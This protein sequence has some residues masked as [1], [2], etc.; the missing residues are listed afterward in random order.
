[1]GRH[2]GRF[3]GLKEV[4]LSWR[5]EKAWRRVCVSASK[6]ANCLGE[7][8]M[9]VSHEWLTRGGSYLGAVCCSADEAEHL[10]LPYKS[11]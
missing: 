7:E 10:E 3:L 4:G 11:L 1:M 6:L 2:I 9:E 5:V 8:K